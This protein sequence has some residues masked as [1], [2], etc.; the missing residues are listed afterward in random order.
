ME[1]K[2]SYYVKCVISYSSGDEENAA[3]DYNHTFSENIY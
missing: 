1:T 2:I 3:V